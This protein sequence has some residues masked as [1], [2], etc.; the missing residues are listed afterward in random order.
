M[1]LVADEL[2]ISPYDNY[3]LVPFHNR[4]NAEK[5]LSLGKCNV[6]FK[7]WRANRSLDANAYSWILQRKIAQVLGSTE[8]E[9]H[10]IM[11]KRYGQCEFPIFPPEKAKFKM[12]RDELYMFAK[13][14]EVNG[15][16]AIMLRHYL[17]S[18]TYDTKEMSIF[19]DGIISECKELDIETITPS[20]LATLKSNWKEKTA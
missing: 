9:I 19:I 1:K 11:L 13:D 12:E 17:G 16:P 18:R 2:K 14:V 20:E 4:K 3:I 7:K 5:I 10:I 8:E 6:E 15:K